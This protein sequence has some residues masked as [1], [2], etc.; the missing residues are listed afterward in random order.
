[1][2]KAGCDLCKLDRNVVIVGCPLVDP[3]HS[4]MSFFSTLQMFDNKKFVQMYLHN[5]MNEGTMGIHH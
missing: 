3:H 4:A 5:Q 1:M 2:P